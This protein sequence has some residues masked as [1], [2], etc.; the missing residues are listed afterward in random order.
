MLFGKQPEDLQPLIIP[1]NALDVLSMNFITSLSESVAY[2]GIYDV[3]LVV[4]DKLYKMCHYIPCRSDMT[5]GELA[6]VIM[7]K[8]IRFHGIP[9]AIISDNRSLVTSRL[10][11]NLINSFQI[12]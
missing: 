7:Q 5:T 8:V 10:W 6:E 3:I 2:R 11:A 12:E 4:V 1:T 9:S